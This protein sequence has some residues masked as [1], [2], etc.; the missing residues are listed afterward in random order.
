MAVLAALNPKYQLWLLQKVELKLDIYVLL[1]YSYFRERR[2]K[3]WITVVVTFFTIQF[4]EGGSDFE[5][6]LVTFLCSGNLELF[7]EFA[8][9]PLER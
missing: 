7:S 8:I 1:N 3:K 9:L 4:H 6:E 5:A 2:R